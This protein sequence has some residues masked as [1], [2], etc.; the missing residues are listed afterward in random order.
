[1]TVSPMW[2]L[3]G[4]CVAIVCSSLL[5]GV[6]PNLVKLTHMRMQSLISVIGGLML[7]VALL[8]QLPHALVAVEGSNAPHDWC[9][10]W[11]L[12]GVLLTF[13][14]LRMFHAHHHEPLEGDPLGAP[15]ANC[16]HDHDHDHDH[17]REVKRADET[18]SHAHAHQHAPNAAGASWLG[19]L[20]GLSLH[21]LLDGIALSAHVEADALHG[22]VGWLLGLG[23]FAGIVL[24]KPLDSL[25]ITTLMTARGWSK[26]ARHLVNVLYSLMCPLGA[27]LF[28]LGVQQFSGQQ[29][30]FIS[31]G[32]AMSAGVFLC[33]ALSDL[34]PEIDFH[35]HNRVR[36]T[37]SLI[38]GV[39]LAWGI[40]F[41]EPEHS[42][43]S[44][45]KTKQ[46]DEH[47]HKHKHKDHD[48]KH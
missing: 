22:Q 25:S 38:V 28:H 1:M 47:D 9:V 33:I 13:L 31:A 23:T 15:P 43:D 42:H 16:D 5:G 17:G 37:A 3:S 20:L 41:L 35:S 11:M 8:H 40:G 27:L 46:H 10:M 7:G 30:Q 48:H 6:L 21:T 44:G 26:S 34:L 45:S 36:L 29:A 24:H 39:A 19:I 14:L 12:G 4:Y 2:L 18:H 32:L